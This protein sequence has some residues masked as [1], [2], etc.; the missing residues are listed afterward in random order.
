MEQY[1]MQASL[2]L[3]IL[4][5]A[6]FFARFERRKNKAEEIVLIAVLA[7]TAAVSR[8]PFAGLPSVQPVSF[9]IMVTAYIFGAHIGFMTGAVAAIVSNMFFGQGPWTIWQMLAWGLVGLVSGALRGTPFMRNR[10]LRVFTGFILGFV[11]GIIMDFWMILRMGAN[12]GM[13]VFY[14]RLSFAFNLAHAL[15][16]IFFIIIFFKQLTRI[17][18]RIKNKYGLLE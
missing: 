10:I 14:F 18:E 12:L 13:F 16:N 11:F 1:Y 9:L 17:L 3:V 5:C 8:I 2:I 6:P 15:S 4:A 7:A